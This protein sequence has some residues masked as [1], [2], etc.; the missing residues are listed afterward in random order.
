[1]DIEKIIRD[2]TREHYQDCDDQ[3]E[4]FPCICD[5]ITEERNYEEDYSKYMLDNYEPKND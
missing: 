4:G 2:K 1:M 3:P 5:H